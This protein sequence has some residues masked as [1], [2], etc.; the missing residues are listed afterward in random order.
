MKKIFVGLC[1]ILLT[2]ISITV[3][4]E[5]KVGILDLNKVLRNSQDVKSMNNTIHKE[6]DPLGKEIAKMRKT[7]KD[8]A[9]AYN[10]NY[11]KQSQ[12]MQ[13]LTRQ[14]ILDENKQLQE[15][16][17]TFRNKLITAQS[18]LMQPIL[19]KITDIVTGIAEAQNFSLVMLKSV[20]LYYKSAIDITDQVIKIMQEQN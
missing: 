4:A 14:K 20:T 12:V 18:N 15:K 9:D 10:R 3:L 5:I 11:K 13:R 16:Q 19:Q 6:F 1:F 17:A 7:V 2:G 8:D